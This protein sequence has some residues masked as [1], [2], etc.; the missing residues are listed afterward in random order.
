MRVCRVT[1]PKVSS[2]CAQKYPDGVQ[3]ASAAGAG[4][5][6]ACGNPTGYLNT[7]TTRC[8]A[9]L[10]VSSLKPSYL[11]TLWAHCLA[12]SWALPPW[13][14]PSFS[15]WTTNNFHLEV[16]TP[17]FKPPGKRFAFLTSFPQIPSKKSRILETAVW[18]EVLYEPGQDVPDCCRTGS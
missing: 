3:A 15:L 18:K 9:P 16:Q 14:F 7:S 5:A 2:W 12:L 8:L 10:Q 11:N 6:A 13:F 17:R 4:P 1:L